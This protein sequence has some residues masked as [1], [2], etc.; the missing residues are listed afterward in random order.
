MLKKPTV[1]G[2][3]RIAYND[4]QFHNVPLTVT[5]KSVFSQSKFLKKV[6]NACPPILIGGGRSVVSMVIL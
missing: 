4:F 3:K 5:I 6:A 2:I 1:I